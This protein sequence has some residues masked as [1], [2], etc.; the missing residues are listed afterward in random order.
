DHGGI[1]GRAEAVQFAC[2]PIQPGA[3][4]FLAPGQQT[5][6]L[7]H[8]IGLMPAMKLGTCDRRMVSV[9]HSLALKVVNSPLRHLATLP[10]TVLSNLPRPSCTCCCAAKTSIT[11][12]PS[13]NTM[14]SPSGTDTNA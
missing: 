14:P 8:G 6:G 7:G 12:W 9:S 2:H 3:L 1:R 13:R 10:V 4:Q 11:P 5:F